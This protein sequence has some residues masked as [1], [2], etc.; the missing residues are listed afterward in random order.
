M[1]ESLDREPERAARDFLQFLR[2]AGWRLDD[3]RGDGWKRI[4]DEEWLQTVGDTGEGRGAW[5]PRLIELC[6]SRGWETGSAKGDDAEQ[7]ADFL[8]GGGIAPCNHLILT[9][10]AADKRK[11]LFKIV[12]ERGEILF[13]PRPRGDERKRQVLV[14]AAA[15]LLAAHGKKMT[16]AAWTALGEKTGFELRTSMGALE[17]LISY[18]GGRPSI[19]ETDVTQVVE[20]TKEDTIFELTGALVSREAGRC[21][22]VLQD[23]LDQGVNHLAIISMIVREVRL[24]HQAKLFLGSG[25]LPPFNDRIDYARF[26]KTIYPLCKELAATTSGEDRSGLAAQHPYVIY[27]VLRHADRFTSSFLVASLAELLK[28]DISLKTTGRDPR[29]ALERFVIDFCA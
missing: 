27:N 18:T 3:L 19:E 21:L 24:L 20:K 7:L 16:P 9:T 15:K 23:L 12:A 22:R 25:K 13:F 28:I 11:K 5:L 8:G 1:R 4:T 2:L 14:A 10:D 26:Q 29:L 17:K 6:V